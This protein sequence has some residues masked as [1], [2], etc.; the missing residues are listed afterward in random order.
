MLEVDGASDNEHD[1][2]SRSSRPYALRY[3]D[4]PTGMQENPNACEPQSHPANLPDND[5]SSVVGLGSKLYFGTDNRK[6]RKTSTTPS[7]SATEADDESGS[8]LKGLPAPPARLRKGLK[9]GA[10]LGTPSPLL[11]PSYL[12]DEKRREALEA[13]FK[14]RSS[15]QSHTSTDEE[16]LRTREKFVNRR[17]AELIRRT[18]ETTLFLSVGCIACWKLLLLPVPTGSFDQQPLVWRSKRG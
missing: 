8:L 13:Q 17:R 7:D 10:T 11:T 14:R 18:T 15:L 4:G 6:R 2:C 9:N 12:D 16:T 1:S 5:S 3:P